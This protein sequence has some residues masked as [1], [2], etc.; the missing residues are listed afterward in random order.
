[1]WTKGKYLV[2]CAKVRD[3]VN[4]DVVGE[5]FE[6]VTVVFVDSVV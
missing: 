3:V 2:Q 1:M 6:A 5:L 4:A